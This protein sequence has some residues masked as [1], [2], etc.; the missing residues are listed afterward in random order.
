M[1]ETV[2]CVVCSAVY[3]TFEELL[4]HEVKR[5]HWIHTYHNKLRSKLSFSLV[6]LPSNAEL[7][8]EVLQFEKFLEVIVLMHFSSFLLGCQ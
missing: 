2:S 4:L 6:D 7:L 3:A 8:Q 1:T 5:G